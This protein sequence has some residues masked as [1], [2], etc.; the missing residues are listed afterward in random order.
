MFPQWLPRTK[1][2]CLFFRFTVLP[3]FFRLL[4]FLCCLVAA[5]WQMRYDWTY[6]ESYRYGWTVIPLSLY[7]FH[8]RWQDRPPADPRLPSRNLWAGWI[9]LAVLFPLVWLFREANPDW[10]PIGLALTVI[11]VAA[12]LLLLAEAGGPPW[13]RHF[14]GPVL[15]FM[16]AIPWPS[17]IERPVTEVL[18]PANAAVTLE[19]LHWLNIP[20][21][22]SGHLITLREGTLGVEEACSGIRSLQSTLM[23]ALFLGELNQLRLSS[24]AVLLGSGILFALFT[25]I[26]RTIGLSTAAARH[27]LSA[28]HDWH[29]TAGLLALGANL[30][31]LFTL[32]AF[33]SKKRP[34]ISTKARFPIPFQ[35]PA[36][37][38]H[39][40]EPT[41]RNQ[42]PGTTNQDPRTRNQEQRTKNQEPRTKK[43][44]LPPSSLLYASLAFTFPF[45]A[46]WYGRNEGTDPPP[47]HLALPL[48]APGF[49]R[50]PL[51]ERTLALLRQPSGWSARWNT[52]EG[53]AIQGFYFEW[54]PGKISTEMGQIHNPGICLRSVGL[55]LE[56]ELEPIPVSVAGS[57]L[58]AR[59]LR[60]TDS[61]R[62]L[63][64][65]Y[66]IHDNNQAKNT[67]AMK[68]HFRLQPVLDGRRSG[69][70]QLIEV[71]L[72]G[73]ASEAEI[74]TTFASLLRDNF[75]NA[76][77]RTD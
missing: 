49:H 39:N 74:T 58:S 53:K 72:W 55:H 54:E 16:V 76:A 48:D 19:A 29:D 77:W 75:E 2:P 23:I 44:S 51:D 68:H 5:I 30:A 52:T 18:M 35:T 27:G 20:A 65:L 40:Q 24:R 70:Q 57:N 67:A 13:L 22:R 60:F 12:A 42:Q 33:L 64:V 71:G 36:S 62:V 31:C 1:V 38:T 32:T 43:I 15:F 66:L 11:T 10:R 61:T 8:L 4:P 69:G 73:E 45:T 41:T 56:A 3:C 26:L 28:A 14:A 50:L 47:W 37:I 63:H 34:P 21:I 25:N 46:W 6:D 17:V 7:L 9:A 59:V